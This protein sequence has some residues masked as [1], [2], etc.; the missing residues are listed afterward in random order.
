MIIVLLISL[1][2]SIMATAFVT[3]QVN[4]K[5]L[6]VDSLLNEKAMYMA[7]SGIQVAFSKISRD[8]KWQGQDVP[9][10]Q[11]PEYTRWIYHDG[12]FH[13]GYKVTSTF[14]P[15]NI[16]AAKKGSYNYY[17]TSTG[18]V[19]DSTSI[20]PAYGTPKLITSRTMI[21][22]IQCIMDYNAD[23]DDGGD[24]GSLT[25]YTPIS[26]GDGSPAILWRQFDYFK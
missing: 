2:L 8:S 19:I 25:H 3:F 12:P 20:D 11:V 26:P 24:S 21:A 14:N 17:V 13:F 15:K 9:N 6:M 16:P 10:P 23:H 7:D 22:Y 4:D 5:R 18:V 1:I